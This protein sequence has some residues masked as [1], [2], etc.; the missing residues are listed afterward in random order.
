[1]INPN[2]PLNI[3]TE[4]D[5]LLKAHAGDAEITGYART[6]AQCEFARLGYPLLALAVK[7]IRELVTDTK[8]NVAMLTRLE[9]LVEGFRSMLMT[10][11]DNAERYR[12]LLG[13]RNREVAELR[14]QLI[15]HE[16]MRAT[17]EGGSEL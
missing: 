5:A 1:M 11:I 13:E 14:K 2:D 12:R 10:T 15:T 16:Q 17:M 7:E 8:H 4:A 9:T 3:C 6:L